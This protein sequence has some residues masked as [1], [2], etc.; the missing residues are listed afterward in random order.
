MPNYEVFCLVIPWLEAVVLMRCSFTEVTVVMKLFSVTLN[1]VLTHPSCEL[2]QPTVTED[3]AHLPPE[4]RRK[5]LQQKLEEICK[6]LQKEVDQRCVCMHTCLSLCAFITIYMRRG[7]MYIM[8]FM[9]LRWG[10]VWMF[11]LQGTNF[12]WK[13]LSFFSLISLSLSSLQRGPR[14]D[15]RCLWEKSSNGRPC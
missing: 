6:E 12:Y 10:C 1:T 4:Q 5:R 8:I 7:T 13:S 14:E 11:T 3:F 2:L 9:R 15:E